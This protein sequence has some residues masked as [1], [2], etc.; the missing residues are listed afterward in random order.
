MPISPLPRSLPTQR[1]ERYAVS[2][3]GVREHIRGFGRGGR[4]TDD[5]FGARSD[6]VAPHGDGPTVQF[7]QAADDRET[8]AQPPLG[9]CDRLPLLHE[10]FENVR[11][12][13]RRDAY[14]RIAHRHPQL[15][16][17]LRRLYPDVAVGRR[18]L[19]RIGQEV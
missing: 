19:G 13:L 10:Q 9:A 14:P 17:G 11:H 18:V 16:I 7:H 15:A 2:E 6:P 4:Q 5:E 12:H 3:S 8:D 1:R